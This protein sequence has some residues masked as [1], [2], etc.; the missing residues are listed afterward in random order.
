MT[1]SIEQVAPLTYRKK[2]QLKE[3]TLPD[4]L[5]SI[6]DAAFSYCT[7]LRQITIPASVEYIGVAAFCCS[8]L[9]QVSFLGLPLKM[10][11][12]IFKGCKQLQAVI[13]PKGCKQYFAAAL[14][15]SASVLKEV[16]E[17]YQPSA[18]MQAKQLPQKQETVPLP[19]PKAIAK[20]AKQTKPEPRCQLEYNNHSFS[21]KKL[22]L[23]NLVDLFGETVSS[24]APVFL[25]R[26]KILFIILPL[27]LSHAIDLAET[28]EY[29]IPTDTHWFSV[30]Y[31]VKYLFRTPRILVFTQQHD[32]K[33]YFYDEVCLQST[34]HGEILV[35]TLINK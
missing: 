31:N 26:K 17:H 13:V 21:W 1:S 9:E 7:S 22:D 24:S 8:G 11:P 20:P 32:G 25:F 14:D 6:G 28:K 2:Q 10:E 3:V 19:E 33:T 15:V 5:K 34:L 16:G 30:K 35:K 4:G 23:V 27:S 29:S 18:T 12:A